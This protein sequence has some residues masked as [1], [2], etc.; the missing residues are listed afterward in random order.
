MKSNQQDTL[1]MESDCPSSFWW[2]S[3]VRQR[4]PTR[5]IIIHYA[6]TDG[7]LQAVWKQDKKKHAGTAD[8][9]DK[10][11]WIIDN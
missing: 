6:V 9:Y 2:E 11:H 5:Q 1:R 7:L 4:P 3:R 8:D 10:P